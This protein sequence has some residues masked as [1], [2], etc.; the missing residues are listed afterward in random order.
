MHIAEVHSLYVKEVL[1][2]LF[3]MDEAVLQT[4]VADAKRTKLT[5]DLS[6]ELS[7][8]RDLT[9]E[10]KGMVKSIEVIDYFILN[11]RHTVLVKS[12]VKIGTNPYMPSPERIVKKI[13]EVV[14]F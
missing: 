8:Y 14:K 12:P 6:A 5:I 11:G 13:E 10:I 9:E 3:G 1:Q 4:K 2:K 7:G